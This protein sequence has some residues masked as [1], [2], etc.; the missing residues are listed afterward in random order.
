MKKFQLMIVVLCFI[1]AG[2]AMAQKIEFASMEINYGE[3]EQGADGL[4]EFTFKNS[5]DQPLVIT[6]ARGSCGCTVPSYAKEPINGGESGSIQVRYDT[7]RL[8]AFTKFVTVT[9]NDA[10]N[11]NVRLTIRGTVKAKETTGQ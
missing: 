5:G 8:G 7:N 3:I 4:R 2:N 10:E 9:T 6:S 11:P 1:A